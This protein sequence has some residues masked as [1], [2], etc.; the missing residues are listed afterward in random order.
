MKKFKHICKTG[1]TFFQ[2]Y[3]VIYSFTLNNSAIVKNKS[4][5][6]VKH[7]NFV[8]KLKI[9]EIHLCFSDYS[10]K[11]SAFIESG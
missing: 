11:L 4:K 3:N 7:V 5:T 6:E 10:I 8:K 2:Y 9:T 1:K